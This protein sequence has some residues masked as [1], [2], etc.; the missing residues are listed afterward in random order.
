MES[1]TL[2]DPCLYDS[3][4]LEE[5]I[6]DMARRAAQ[7]LSGHERVAVI[8][9]LR[10]GAPLAERLTAALVTQYRLAPPLRL[11]LSIKRYADD[12]T[13]LHPETQFTENAAHASLDLAGYALLVV[14]DVL[15]TGHSLLRA[16]EYLARKQPAAIY[17]AML[18][19]R[20]VTRLPL[21][22]DVVGL[23]LQVAPP[24]IVE[25]H[26]PP[27]EAEFKIVLRKPAAH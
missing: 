3:A 14:D 20:H 10:R 25:C 4:Q 12:L 27:Y 2:P 19:D 23:H 5:V 1:A 13:L 26:V 6:A 15:Y 11:D 18:A 7:L 21:H 24:D 8:G 9:V 16:V 17:A 22:A